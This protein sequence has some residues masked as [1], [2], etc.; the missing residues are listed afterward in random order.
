MMP[1]KHERADRIERIREKYSAG[2][3]DTTE[4]FVTDLLTDLRHFC[5]VVAWSSPS[6]MRWLSATTS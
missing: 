2:V 6:E 4:D 5:D 1:M 3:C